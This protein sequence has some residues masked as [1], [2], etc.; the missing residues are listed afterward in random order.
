MRTIVSGKIA[1]E[2]SEWRHRGL[3]DDRLAECLAAR[4]D[5]NI[6]AGRVLLRWLGFFGLLMLCASMLGLVGMAMGELLEILAP[7]LL[8]AFA[9]FLWLRGAQLAAD[10]EQRYPLSGAALLTA[11]IFGAQSAFMLLIINTGISLPDGGLPVITLLFSA[12]AIYTAYRYGLRW[13][14]LLGVLMIFH[15][16]GNWHWTSGTGSYFLWIRD[17]PLTL[18]ISLITLALGLWHESKV[19]S[20]LSHRH[21]GFGQVYI[22]FGLLYANLCMWILSLPQGELDWVLAFTAAGIAQIVAGARLNDSRFTGFGIVFLS[23]SFYTRLFEWFWDEVSR[24]SFFL[25]CGVIAML[26]GAVFEYRARGQNPQADL[27]EA[28]Q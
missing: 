3:I 16:I 8:S 25:V 20:E 24:G 26:L 15:A 1:G 9:G 17:E 2:V 4:Y 6:S 12:G 10:P 21:V 13:P 19:E 11:G 22:V 23:L 14:L 7:V 18:T 5:V 27:A 28:G